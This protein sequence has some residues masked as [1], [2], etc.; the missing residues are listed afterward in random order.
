MP[1]AQLTQTSLLSKRLGFIHMLLDAQAG[2]RQAGPQKGTKNNRFLQ[3]PFKLPI[4]VAFHQHTAS[5]RCDPG[6]KK[7]DPKEKMRS[8]RWPR[9]IRVGLAMLS[10]NARSYSTLQR[11]LSHEGREAGKQGRHAAC[12]RE[13]GQM[14]TRVSRT[15]VWTRSRVEQKD[16]QSPSPRQAPERFTNPKEMLCVS[17]KVLR[18]FPPQRLPAFL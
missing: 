18:L 13:T 5:L 17:S 10:R 16:L 11:C 9:S 2:S 3:F 4:P 8:L 14:A 7:N 12:E 15:P 1:A 6:F